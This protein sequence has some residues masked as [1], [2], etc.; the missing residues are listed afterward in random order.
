VTPAIWYARWMRIESWLAASCVALSFA[1][2][3]SPSRSVGEGGGA[4]GDDQAPVP[5]SFEVWKADHPCPAGARLDVRDG[6]AG[7][8]AYCILPDDTKEGPTASWSTAGVQQ[9]DALYERDKELREMTWDDRGKPLTREVLR[10]DGKFDFTLWQ[11]DGTSTTK[12]K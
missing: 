2:N 4:A 5:K 8:N 1:C 9:T 10:P 7:R 6:E 12:V 11:P 3:S